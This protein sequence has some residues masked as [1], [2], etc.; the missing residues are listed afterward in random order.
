MRPSDRSLRS[1]L[2]DAGAF[3]NP[4]VILPLKLVF[5]ALEQRGVIDRDLLRHIGACQDVGL[6]LLQYA[7]DRALRVPQT[8]KLCGSQ[9]CDSQSSVL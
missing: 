7:C 9:A 1:P 6:L 4:R 8:A 2:C 3:L 5:Q